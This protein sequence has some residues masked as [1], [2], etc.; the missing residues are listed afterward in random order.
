MQWD[1]IQ[2]ERVGLI[3]VSV[4]LT[5]GITYAL[6]KGSRQ[7][8]PIV[9]QPLP[10]QSASPAAD[11]VPTP[12][13]PTPAQLIVH[14]A[15]GV[16]K[17]GLLHLPPEARIDDAIK[18][19]GGAVVDADLDQI[20]LAAKLT[21]GEQVFVPRK[22]HP[23]DAAKIGDTYKGGLVGEAQAAP[24]ASRGSHKQPSGPVSLNTAT[25]SQLESLP[26]VGP[27][28]AHKIMDYR[29]EHGGFS[30]V[31]EL[32]AVKG[33]GPKKLEAMRRYLKL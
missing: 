2:T 24:H 7:P 28:T 18:A 6:V 29:Q 21:D 32:M 11:Q 33:I 5:A 31:E 15:G 3:G 27:S 10:I 23:E 17:P 16:N 19:A 12:E 1:R 9:F 14:A 22:N 26:G 25:A 30:S 4:L 13:K 20:N 8:A